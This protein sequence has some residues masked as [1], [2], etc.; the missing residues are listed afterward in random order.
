MKV[1]NDAFKTQKIA[2]NGPQARKS[3]YSNPLDPIFL[4]H[5]PLETTHPKNGHAKYCKCTAEEKTLYA[6]LGMFTMGCF[7]IKN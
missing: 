4:I 2:A 5:N 3:H 7:K 6:S 1:V